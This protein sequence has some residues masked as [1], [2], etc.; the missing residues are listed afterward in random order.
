MFCVR[1]VPSSAMR[2]SS[3]SPHCP[4]RC[5]IG[6]SNRRRRDRPSA[7]GT[8]R[9]VLAAAIGMMQQRIGLAPAPDRHHQSIGDELGRHGC[10]H[11]PA[12]H[13]AGEQIDHGSHKEPAFRRPDIGEIGNPFAVRRRRR[14]AAVEYVGGDGGDLPLVAAGPVY[15]QSASVQLAIQ[16]SATAIT[17]QFNNARCAQ[18]LIFEIPKSYW[19][20]QSAAR[21][22]SWPGSCARPW[23]LPMYRIRCSRRCRRQIWTRSRCCISSTDI[24][25]ARTST[26]RNGFWRGRPFSARSKQH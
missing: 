8:A 12:D 16:E 23:P 14:E 2:R 1:C 4:K 18:P 19:A 7:A 21:V 22:G 11:R 3:P 9:W 5:Q 24:A 17:I 20:V 25:R 10:A 13:T 6:S 15:S 26:S